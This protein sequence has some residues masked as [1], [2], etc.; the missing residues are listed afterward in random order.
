MKGQTQL[1][2]VLGPRHLSFHFPEGDIQ[3][4]E[5]EITAIW[6]CGQT[7][8]GPQPRG[9][10]SGGCNPAVQV[11]YRQSGK[12]LRR[13]LT[14]KFPISLMPITVY[15]WGFA[16]LNPAKNGGAPPSAPTTLVCKMKSLPW[17]ELCK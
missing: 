1:H 11:R 2:F 15:L 14:R 3:F 6:N 12:S 4:E 9:N 7:K 5:T 16:F 17:L 13:E 8:K 10:Q